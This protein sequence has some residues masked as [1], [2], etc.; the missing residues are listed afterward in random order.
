MG[1]QAAELPVR[2]VVLFK[3]GIGYFARAGE[4]KPGETALLEFKASDM[5]DVLKSLTV[6]DRSGGKIAG[7]RYDAS[8]PLDRRLAHFPFAVGSGQ[9][10]SAFLDHMKGARLEIQYNARTLAGL[11]LGARATSG[12]QDKGEREILS[13]LLDSGEIQSF[14]LAAIPS[15][16]FS[17]PAMQS[18]LRDYMALLGQAR[19]QD[20]RRLRIDSVEERARQIVA[21]YMLPSA[22]WKSSYRLLFGE[23][24]DPTLEGWAIVDNTTGEDW[25]GVRLAVVS[26]RPVS[27]QSLLYE[28]RYRNRP[29]AELAEDRPV[30]PV[31]H[32]GAVGGVIGGLAVPQAAPPPAPEMAADDTRRQGK[33]LARAAIRD[34]GTAVSESILVDTSN[35]AATAEG[36]EL[37]DLFEY[38]FS[39]PV[40]IKKNESAM[41][42]FLQQKLN[43]RKLLI[44][45]ESYG[46][47]PMNA[48]EI[49]N[50]TGKTLDGGPL[51]V[52]EAGAYAGEALM[53]TLKAG[54]KRLISYAVDLGTRVTTAFDSS[55]DLVRELRYRRGILVTTNAVAETRTFTI[56]NVDPK[57]KTLVIEHPK[58]EGF[59]LVNMKP[60]EITA[61]AYRFEVNLP[62]SSEQKFAITEERISAQTLQITSLTP[63]LLFSYSQNKRI[64]E[65]ARRQLEQLA[66]MKQHLASLDGE[67]RDLETQLKELSDDQN[68]LRENIRSLNSVQGQQ[69][70]VQ[71]YAQKLAQQESQVAAVRDQIAQK[72]KDRA[73]AEAQINALI[74]KMEF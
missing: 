11:I 51:T 29:V 70:Q 52:Y 42:P 4:L 55:Q 71:Q 50:S 27:F 20:K 38:R 24:G 74:A 48:A 61:N 26:G 68:R 1:T 14:D 33:A 22:V 53:E 30:G 58:R 32:A 69:A 64:A 3:H 66:Q 8:E 57:P 21:T 6:M 62:P 25:N 63:E 34:F 44:Y 36:R 15:L 28:P 40:T 9:P 56:K 12:G 5:N 7:I 37:G 47:N 31:V 10:L 13:L 17:D 35:V 18:Q 60:A 72:R 73:S 59:L 41:L 49:T 39:Q 67:L 54:D 46:Q 19:S 65:A 23:T 45:S 43:S 2:D 16:K